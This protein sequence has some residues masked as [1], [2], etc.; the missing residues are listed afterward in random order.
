MEELTVIASAFQHGGIWMKFILAAQ[1]IS[2]AIM[3]E[4]YITLY[5]KRKVGESGF[6]AQFEGLI[7]QGQLTEVMQKAQSEQNSHP[8]AGAIIA[9]VKSAMKFGGK[10]E[11]QG[12]MDEVLLAENS[13]LEKKTGFLAMLAN[14]GTLLGLLGTIVGMIKSFAA[15]ANAN[16][17]E[18]A[19]LLSAGISEA[20]Y[21][22]AYGLI[23]AIPA[24][25]MYAVLSNRANQLSEDLNQSALKVYNW[26]SY[27]FES[28]SA[29]EK[30]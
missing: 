26:L 14:V 27:T 16:P 9:G 12:K 3:V 6:V 17:V 25:V 23:M 15:V 5:V 7:R 18:K 8:V 28:V 20:M 11:I 21:A 13:R 24:I 19:S 4:R 30:R 10:E 1:V 29:Q 22:T 2:I